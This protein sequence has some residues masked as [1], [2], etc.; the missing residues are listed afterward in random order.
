MHLEVLK[1]EQKK[2]FEKL[3]QFPEFYLVGGTGLAL[4]IGHRISEDFDLFINKD[5]LPENLITKIRRVF[6]GCEIK[7]SLKHSEQVNVL[8]NGVKVDF[9]KYKYPLIFQLVKFNKI[10]MACI[11]E[12][13]LMKA[14]TL[15]GRASIKDYVDL[16]FIL[17]KKSISLNKIIDN[18]NKKY[19]GEFNDRLFLEQLTYFKDISSANIEFLGEKVSKEQMQEF[20]EQEI[21]KIKL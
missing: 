6:D 20:F 19:K 13:A 4:Q 21:K 8:L 3:K 9:V 14:S 10:S 15:G 12:I 5:C 7:F 18:C 1:S 11:S 2:I 16:Y 17:K